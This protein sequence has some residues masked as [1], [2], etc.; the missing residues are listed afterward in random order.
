MKAT[1]LCKGAIAPFTTIKTCLYCWSAFPLALQRQAEKTF[2]DVILQSCMNDPESSSFTKK[3]T[4][5]TRIEWTPKRH[6]H[7][8]PSLVGL[9]VIRNR[10]FSWLCFLA[11]P[12]FPIS[13]VTFTG[14]ALHYSGGT[15]PAFHRSSLL[16]PDGHP[17]PWFSLFSSVSQTGNPQ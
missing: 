15:V 9:A 12:V 10:Q 17:F 7:T 1:Y 16:S 11:S 5:P 3:S 6:S 4:L 8:I 2:P 13:S 14:V